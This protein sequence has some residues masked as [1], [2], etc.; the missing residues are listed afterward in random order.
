MMAQRKQDNTLVAA[1]LR[2][3]RIVAMAMRPAGGAEAGAFPQA[4][5]DANVAMA[6]QAGWEMMMAKVAAFERRFTELTHAALW[7]PIHH[8]GDAL[9]EKGTGRACF[10]Y[11]S[12]QSMVN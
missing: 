8:A 10:A 1:F 5:A 12:A 11:N 4:W 7:Y 6:K 9:R 3:G 2:D